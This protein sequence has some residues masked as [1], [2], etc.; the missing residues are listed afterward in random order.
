MR[1]GIPEIQEAKMKTEKCK[2]MMDRFLTGE[3]SEE[4]AEHLRECSACRE[5]AELDRQLTG[6]PGHLE[7]PEEL[8]RAV[9]AYAAAKK[10]P[11]AKVWDF[12]F[13]LRHAAIPAAAAVMVCFGLVFAFRQSANPSRQ[14][15]AQ[16]QSAQYDLDMVDSEVLLLS[17]RIQ[18]TSVQLSRTAVYDV[19][20]E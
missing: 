20:N 4:V 14:S 15:L 8:D 2:E 5:L 19:I 12:A 9:L 1:I 18:N 3:V 7:V 10:R 16:V 6:M 17:S 13:I 11:A